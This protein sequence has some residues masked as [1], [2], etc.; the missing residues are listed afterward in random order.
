MSYQAI[1]INSHKEYATAA[2][3][4]DLFRQLGLIYPS[5][6]IQWHQDGTHSKREIKKIYPEP[7]KI[8]KR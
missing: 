5:F 4:P 8:I 1:G 7:L 3:Q 2:H 6:S